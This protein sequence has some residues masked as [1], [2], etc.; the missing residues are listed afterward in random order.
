MILFT[1]SVLKVSGNELEN[2]KSTMNSNRELLILFALLRNFQ[3]VMRQNVS[4]HS[5][6]CEN[7]YYRSFAIVRKF[8][9]SSYW[10]LKF[11]LEGEVC[12]FWASLCLLDFFVGHSSACVCTAATFCRFD[13]PRCCGNAGKTYWTPLQLILWTGKLK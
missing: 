1:K 4:E 3:L 12:I 6:R 10:P 8:A 9:G 2:I 5:H 13:S 7:T 11:R